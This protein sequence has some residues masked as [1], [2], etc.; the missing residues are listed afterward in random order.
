MELR[1]TV[2]LG[3]DGVK[4]KEETEGNSHNFYKIYSWD[5]EIYWGVAVA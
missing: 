5:T 2:Y 3:R 1:L 4:M